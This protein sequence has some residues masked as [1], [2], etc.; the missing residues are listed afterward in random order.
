M[1]VG[2]PM[3]DESVHYNHVVTQT[4]FTV[5]K[6]ENV[7]NRVGGSA[8][9][10]LLKGHD[11]AK[12][13]KPQPSRVTT[14]PKTKEPPNRTYTINKTEIRRR[15][16]QMLLTELAKKRLYFWTVTFPEGLPDV[17]AMKALNI[18]LTRMRRDM[19][20]KAYL[21]VAERQQNHTIH[22][23]V[24]FHQYFNVQRVNKF[25]R[26]TLMNLQH[27]FPLILKPEICAKY[28]GIDIAKNKKTRRVV[29]FAHKNKKKALSKYITKYLSKS[30]DK[31]CH[32]AWHCSREYSNLVTTLRI[33]YQEALDLGLY[34]AHA[35]RLFRD[36]QHFSFYILNQELPL[37]LQTLFKTINDRI[38]QLM[39]A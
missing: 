31:F 29:N 1:N 34:D 20:L 33:T 25:M 22:F 26:A 12:K 39:E 14:T 18:W 6:P 23:H 4:G 13:P 8:N 3:P 7:L 17:A 5:L 21:W 38:H 11:L 37:F 30:D 36:E 28:N 19:G 24:L 32:L 35:S 2:K 10:H 16:F 15:I 27:Y 9:Y